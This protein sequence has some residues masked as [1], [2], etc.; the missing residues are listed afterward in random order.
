MDQCQEITSEKTEKELTVEGSFM[1]ELN[2]ENSPDKQE[3][4]YKILQQKIAEKEEETNNK[5]GNKMLDMESLVWKKGEME[6]EED[7]G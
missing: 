1:L 5:I 2:F 7:D 3:E 6:E 4:V